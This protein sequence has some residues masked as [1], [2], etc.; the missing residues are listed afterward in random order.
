M[1]AS[2][3][4]DVSDTAF[5]IAHYRGLEEQRGDPLFRDPLATRLAGAHGEKIAREMPGRAMTEWSVAIRTRLIDDYI[6]KAIAA[7]V[8]TV[9]NL[10]AGLDTRPYR[11]DL[12]QSLQWIEADFPKVID[13][14]TE[15]LNGEQ[16]HCR[17]R[18]VKADLSNGDER[19]R[20]LAEVDAA[21]GKLLVL[22]EGVVPY[23]TNDEVAALAEDLNGLKSA[24]YWIVDYFSP[25]LLDFRRR[26]RFAR[27][28]RNAPFQF[29][30]DDWF[31]F[32]AQH[33]WRRIELRYLVD[34][35]AR[36]KRPMRVPLLM[37]VMA[38]FISKERRKAFREFGYALLEPS[39]RAAD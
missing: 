15:R 33:G 4:A 19:R 25:A 2:S 11:M 30:P 8:D 18:R 6:L 21:A 37:R 29:R 36:L 28:M 32:F 34:E 23:L 13:F 31:Q 10:G 9:L 3:I 39:P 16:P 24:R 5:W 14:K 22:T 17:L 20:M 1:A 7:G 35:A 26:N 12:P 38:L 27:R